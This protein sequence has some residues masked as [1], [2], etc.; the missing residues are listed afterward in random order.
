MVTV[1][2]DLATLYLNLATLPTQM[3]TTPEMNRVY[4]QESRIEMHG[5]R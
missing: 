5:K 2:T 4:H 1:T 3:A